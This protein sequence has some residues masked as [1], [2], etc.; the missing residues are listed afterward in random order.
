MQLSYAPHRRITTFLYSNQSGSFKRTVRKSP[1]FT[2]THRRVH[3]RQAPGHD[4]RLNALILP[5][6]TSVDDCGLPPD[7][8]DKG[9]IAAATGIKRLSVFPCI[10][11]GN[12]G[13]CVR[14]EGKGNVGGVERNQWVCR[15]RGRRLGMTV[16]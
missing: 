13:Q 7:S 8:A 12:D 6:Y 9:P 1:A 11:G 10:V 2:V 5:L 3:P 4:L 16:L 14:R 15:L